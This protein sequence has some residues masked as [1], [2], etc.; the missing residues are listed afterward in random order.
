[1]AC[2]VFLVLLLAMAGHSSATWCVCKEGMGD[3]VLQKSLDYACGAG[4]DCNPIH[5]AGSCYNPNTVRAH[6]NYA[7]NSYFQKK[8]QAQGSC[9]FSGTATV[10][11]SDPSTTGC[12]YPTSASSTTPTSTTPVTTTPTTPTTTTPSSTTTPISGSPYVTTP[13]T[14]VVGTGLGPSGVGINTDM[15]HGGLAL[16]TTSFFSFWTTTSLFSVFM[17]LWG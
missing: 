3:S 2:L 8:G 13:S 17:L 4:A 14:G 1:M 7:V 6:C 5:S 12:V 9:D 11:T 15:S 16:Q 10:S